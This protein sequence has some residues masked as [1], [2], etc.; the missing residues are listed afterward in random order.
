[1]S[2]SVAK[3]LTIALLIDAAANVARLIGVEIAYRRQD[4]MMKRSELEYSARMDAA[5]RIVKDIIEAKH[6]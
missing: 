3:I 6:E 5:E 4:A 2:D 1:M